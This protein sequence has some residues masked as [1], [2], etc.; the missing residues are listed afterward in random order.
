[1]IAGLLALLLFGLRGCDRKTVTTT[2]ISNAAGQAL[3]VTKVTLPGGRA[4][5]VSPNTLNYELQADP[6]SDTPAARRFAFDKLNFDSGSATVRHDDRATVETL[7]DILAAYPNAK[8]RLVGFTDAIGSAAANMQL[9]G[10]RAKAV[11]A[12]L[13]AKGVD[14]GRI[15]TAI[16]GASDPAASNANGDGRAENRRTELEV[17]AE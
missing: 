16:G 7:G 10:E 3:P 14:A 9:G 2:T 1:M 12:A 6:A 17:A 4:I 13:T 15:E 5:D 11:A 8:V